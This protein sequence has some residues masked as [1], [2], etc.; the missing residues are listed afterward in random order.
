MI[1]DGI[2]EGEGWMTRGLEDKVQDECYALCRVQSIDFVLCTAKVCVSKSSC[3]FA[4]Q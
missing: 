2:C 4:T 1:V 3:R